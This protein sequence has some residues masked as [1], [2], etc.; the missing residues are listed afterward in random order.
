MSAFESCDCAQSLAGALGG[1][2]TYRGQISGSA[3]EPIVACLWCAVP[4][5]EPELADVP[6]FGGLAALN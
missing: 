5:V 6:V 2:A 4:S 1:A 3:L